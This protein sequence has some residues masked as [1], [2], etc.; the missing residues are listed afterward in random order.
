MR[1]EFSDNAE[2]DL[3]AIADYIARD[4]PQRALSFAQD[5]RRRCLGLATFPRRYPLL[6]GYEEFGIRKAVH[7]AYLIFFQYD[8]EV[9]SIVHVVHGAADYA[10]LFE[11]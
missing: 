10:H 3:E 8:Q 2:A 5:L 1:V 4:N 9:V 11:A 6:A 7:A